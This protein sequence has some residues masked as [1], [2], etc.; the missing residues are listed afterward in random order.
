MIFETFSFLDD[1]NRDVYRNVV[2]LTDQPTEA[3]ATWRNVYG[4]IILITYSPNRV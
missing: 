2:L 1:K 3:A 4:L